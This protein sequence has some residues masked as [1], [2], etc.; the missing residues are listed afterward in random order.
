MIIVFA[1]LSKRKIRI[2]QAHAKTA[3]N[4][5]KNQTYWAAMPQHVSQKSKYGRHVHS[6][7][8]QQGEVK[9]YIKCP[10]RVRLTSALQYCHRLDQARWL[11]TASLTACL[12]QHTLRA[13]LSVWYVMIQDS[14]YLHC[15]ISMRHRAAV[16]GPMPEA[17]TATGCPMIVPCAVLRQ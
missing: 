16:P 7:W 3:R 15:R 10:F 5:N 8:L 1:V 4:V 2:L 13:M 9:T 12:A 6:C 17:M 11:T 14:S